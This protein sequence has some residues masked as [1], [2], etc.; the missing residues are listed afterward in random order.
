MKIM[1]IGPAKSRHLVRWANRVLHSDQSIE[2]KIYDINFNLTPPKNF[3]MRF[4]I[5]SAINDLRDEQENIYNERLLV[6]RRILISPLQIF[7]E[8]ILNFVL[9]SYSIFCFKPNLIH[10]HWLNSIGSFVAVFLAKQF[11]IPVMITAWGSD[12]NDLM[13]NKSNH[14][15]NYLVTYQLKNSNRITCDAKHLKNSMIALGAQEN[16]IEIINFGVDTNYFRSNSSKNILRK[17]LG[18]DTNCTWI[19]SNRPFEDV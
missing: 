13:N 12:I 3:F 10:V 2:I 8:L 19:L 14:F 7:I 5:S 9:I 16:K 6:L 11:K 1:I 18:L 4:F 17:S 15:R